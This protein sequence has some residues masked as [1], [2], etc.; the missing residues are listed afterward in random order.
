[1]LELTATIY[2]FAAITVALAEVVVAASGAAAGCRRYF[3]QRFIPSVALAIASDLRLAH[4]P[5]LGQQL[6]ATTFP[7]LQKKELIKHS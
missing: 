2:V 6:P 1:M 4:P 3:F 5:L 7:K